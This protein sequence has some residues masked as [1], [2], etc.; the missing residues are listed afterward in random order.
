[1]AAA[2]WLASCGGGGTGPSSTVVPQVA[3]QYDV[4]A[5]LQQ[6]DCPATPIVLPQPTSVTHTAGASEFTL[7]HGGLRVTGTV[8]RDGSFATQPLAVADPQGPANLAIAGRF[9]TGG[10]E[11]T[12][13]VSVTTPCRYLVG[14]TGSKLGSPNVLG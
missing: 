7:V 14:W 1:M 6:N 5:R 9:T 13:T 3:G 2:L 8:G 12:V 4:V 10:L 11:A